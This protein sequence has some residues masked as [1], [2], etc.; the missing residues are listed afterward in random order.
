MLRWI[1]SQL[2]KDHVQNDD[3]CVRLEGGTNR[4]VC[5]TLIEMVWTCTTRPFHNRAMSQIGNGKREIGRP[6]F[7]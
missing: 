5:A 7:T 1:C 4:E 6:N 2:R 3:I